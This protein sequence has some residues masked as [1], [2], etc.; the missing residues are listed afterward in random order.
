MKDEPDIR[1]RLNGY[2]SAKTDSASQARRRSLFRALAVR[3]YLMSKG[4]R[5]TRI[6]IHALGNK[7][8]SKDPDRVDV[9]IRRS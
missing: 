8:Q 1:I 6:D 7:S 3:K 9:V 4:I 2:A 5:S